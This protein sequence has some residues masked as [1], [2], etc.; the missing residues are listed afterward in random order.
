MRIWVRE[1]FM[2]REE[3]SHL[4]HPTYSKLYYRLIVFSKPSF[5]FIGL[6]KAHEK[7]N[8]VKSSTSYQAKN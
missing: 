2:Q 6:S 7:I 1:L 5:L 8:L 3:A 4:L